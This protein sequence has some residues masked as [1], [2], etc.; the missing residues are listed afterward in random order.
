MVKLLRPQSPETLGDPEL[1]AVLRS[2]LDGR[3]RTLKTRIRS[4]DFALLQQQR[5]YLT[6]TWPEYWHY[7]GLVLQRHIQESECP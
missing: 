3:P 6:L 7:A 4:P 1:V 2:R 5:L